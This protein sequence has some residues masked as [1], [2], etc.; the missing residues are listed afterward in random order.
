MYCSEFIESNEFL[1][2]FI[3]LIII[4]NDFHVSFKSYEIS[5][6]TIKIYSQSTLDSVPASTQRILKTHLPLPLIPPCVDFSVKNKI[7]FCLRDPKDACVSYYKFTLGLEILTGSYFDLYVY[8][9]FHGYFT[10]I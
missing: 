3:L 7:I 10:F 6:I 9:Y 5:Y 2:Y 8:S 1:L 4:K